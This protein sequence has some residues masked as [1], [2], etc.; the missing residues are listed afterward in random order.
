MKPREHGVLYLGGRAG[1]V[2]LQESKDRLHL[3]SSLKK[4]IVP[5]QQNRTLVSLLRLIADRFS[6]FSGPIDPLH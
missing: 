6:V 2:F 5:V 4:L 3:H 1:Q